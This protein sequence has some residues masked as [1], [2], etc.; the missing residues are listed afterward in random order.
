[1]A[2][3]LIDGMSG[4]WDPEQYKDE[5]REAVLEVI[6]EKVE[7]GGQVLPAEKAKSKKATNVVDLMAVLQ[8]SLHH[9]KAS[10]KKPE[11]KRRKAA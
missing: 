2:E 4:K 3:S 7:A 11:K 6:N 1:M 5:Y 10:K 8:E 9:A